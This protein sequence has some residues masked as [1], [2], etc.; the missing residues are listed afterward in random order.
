M[1]KV[2]LLLLAVAVAAG[3][4]FYVVRP[5]PQTVPGIKV[6]GTI[7]ATTVELGFKVPGRIAERLVDEGNR[8]AVGQAI[9]RLESDDLARE[10][11]A[12]TADRDALLAALAELEAG[13]R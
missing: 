1:K 2:A 7:E 12:R 9:A 5:S 3:I 6:S 13:Y 11:A 4:V 8:V 10:K